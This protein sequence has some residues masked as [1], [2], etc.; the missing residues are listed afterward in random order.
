MTTRMTPRSTKRSRTS[1]RSAP[2]TAPSCALPGRPRGAPAGAHRLRR[3]A[4]VQG[5]DHAPPRRARA[6]QHGATARRARARPRRGLRADAS[7][8]ADAAALRARSSAT[9]RAAQERPTA[10]LAFT[11]HERVLAQARARAGRGLPHRLRGRLRRP[12]RRRGGRD[13]RRRRARGR[14]RACAEGTLPPFLGIRIKSF[15][16]EWKA[17]G[18]R[19]LELFLDTLLGATG[20]TPARQLRRHAA[21]GHD[22]RAAARRWCACSSCSSS[23]TG[24]PPGSAA[25]GADDRGRRRRCSAPDGRSPLP[26]FLDAVRGALRRRALRHLRLHRVVQHHGGVPDAWTTRCATSPRA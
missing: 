14:A 6:A 3:R 7:A 1:T 19:T 10:W 5:R 16:E 12:P 13:R 9:R 4:P 24:S 15:G 21:Q 8:D 22:R 2:P 25:A 20:G 11:V 23:A 17:R 26:G 18:A